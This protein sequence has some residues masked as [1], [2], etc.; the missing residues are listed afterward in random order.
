M[1]RQI[2]VVGRV[3][4]G[5]AF[6]GDALISADVA[7]GDRNV[8]FQGLDL[9]RRFD[10]GGCETGFDVPLEMAVEEV[11]AGVVGHPAEGYG[12]GAWHLDGV[13]AHGWCACWWVEWE[14]GSTT[15]A[16]N[17][18]HV[19]AVKMEG[20]PVDIVIVESEFND[21]VV[22][23]DD[24]VGISAVDGRI[25]DVCC[26]S[27]HCSVESGYH[28]SD[29]VDVIKRA[30]PLAV[31]IRGEVNGH[32]LRRCHWAKLRRSIQ[33]GEDGI[34]KGLRSDGD[35]CWKSSG[36]VVNKECRDLRM[37]ESE[38]VK[39]GF[40]CLSI[41]SGRNQRGIK[42]AST[43][44]C[45]D[46]E[47][48]CASCLCLDDDSVSLSWSNEQL[49]HRTLRG[50]NSI[51]FHNSHTVLI[52]LEVDWREGSDVDD[53][54]QVLLPGHHWELNI[55]RFV[56]QKG[57]RNWFRAIV[58]VCIVHGLVI[59]DQ[60]RS[61]R[62]VKVADCH[63][64]FR[65]NLVWRVDIL[66]DEWASE[67]INILSTNMSMIPVGTVLVDDEFIDKCSTRLDWALSNHRRSIGIGCVSL[68]DTV[69]MDCS[70]LVSKIVCNSDDNRIPYIGTD[71]GVWP[72]S[73]DA[74]KRSLE[75]VRSCI[76]PSNT[77]HVV[78]SCW[79]RSSNGR[80]CCRA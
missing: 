60:R 14:E 29:I 51:N 12:A 80:L 23:K 65:G 42:H 68:A 75:S 54:E 62:M 2:L 28:R 16:R 24:R 15:R 77:P 18:L 30:S 6:H 58:V 19:V 74:D 35:W 63:H 45:F 13:T 36:R 9:R 39:W 46:S 71:S 4:G 27:V 21:G 44:R 57:I 78:P 69:E 41:E 25:V 11:D 40:T 76:Y 20:M 7:V 56:D 10:E 48:L 32:E 17:E 59:I 5:V 47:V 49:V 38:I 53:S 52:E 26:G 64:V 72:L 70:R 34:I 66:D 3:A 31:G 37:L 33:G 50:V 55:L 22:R 73:V 61:F 8:E 43:H 1:A 79:S 67:S